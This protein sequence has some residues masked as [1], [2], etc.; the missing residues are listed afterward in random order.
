MRYG[1]SSAKQV[2]VDVIPRRKPV[3]RGH[4]VVD[5]AATSRC[6]RFPWSLPKRRISL[7]ALTAVYHRNSRRMRHQKSRRSLPHR[8]ILNRLAVHPPPDARFLRLQHGTC[9]TLSF[10]PCRRNLHPIASRPQR[11]CP[12]NLVGVR[13]QQQRAR[14]L[15]SNLTEAVGIA[16]PDASP[17]FPISVAVQTWANP[18]A[19]ESKATRTIRF[20]L[21]PQQDL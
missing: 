15:V 13:L 5:L 2:V 21:H 18:A 10:E 7:R 4:R 3:M 8:Q 1:P 9:A 6:H 20:I 14:S 17:T 16:P 12:E 11:R 19:I